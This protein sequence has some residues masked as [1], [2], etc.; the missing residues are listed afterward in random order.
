MDPQFGTTAVVRFNCKLA[1]VFNT[2]FAPSKC[3]GGH[4][5]DTVSGLCVCQFDKMTFSKIDF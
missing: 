5:K 4:G 3:L 2:S 1:D